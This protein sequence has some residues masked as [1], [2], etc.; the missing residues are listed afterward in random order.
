MF[1][2]S[3]TSTGYQQFKASMSKNELESF[4]KKIREKKKAIYNIAKC[5]RLSNNKEKEKKRGSIFAI[6]GKE[7]LQAI[8]TYFTK[9]RHGKKDNQANCHVY[10]PLSLG[11]QV[12]N[13]SHGEEKKKRKKSTWEVPSYFQPLHGKC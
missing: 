13:S 3:N 10:L 7:K 11:G 2:Y 4:N 5:Y 12:F 6:N 8:N 1:K 9:P